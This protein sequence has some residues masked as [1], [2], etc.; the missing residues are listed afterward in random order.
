MV[1]RWAQVKRKNVKFSI[2][3]GPGEHL[4]P[5]CDFRRMK[6]N[7]SGTAESGLGLLLIMFALL[8]CR[9]T[10]LQAVQAAARPAHL[11]SGGDAA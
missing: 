4:K 7:H 6:Q 3:R 2:A 10:T 5:V 1:F 11:S 9:L 8:R